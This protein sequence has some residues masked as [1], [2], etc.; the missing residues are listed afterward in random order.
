MC[1]R[2]S[3]L[4]VFNRQ[5]RQIDWLHD[6]TLSIDPNLGY[7]ASLNQ[8]PQISDDKLYVLDSG[9]TLHIFEKEQV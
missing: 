8:A 3:L 9:G 6:M 2:D 4:G 5:T 1:I 7:V